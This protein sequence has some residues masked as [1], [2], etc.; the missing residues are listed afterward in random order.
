MPH[1][2]SCSFLPKI[3]AVAHSEPKT[4]PVAKESIYRY[5]FSLAAVLFA[6]GGQYA[7]DLLFDFRHQ[8]NLHF[9][10]LVT[11]A[12]PS[13][14][15]LC[16]ACDE[17]SMPVTSWWRRPIRFF[18]RHWWYGTYI[19]LFRLMTIRFTELPQ[20]K[21]LTWFLFVIM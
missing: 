6:V 19:G 5:V 12:F 14:L 2:F 20:S 7:P 11:C 15:P 21:C 3:A 17:I 4:H 8:A 13:V 16:T 10:Y 1:I 9:V 18:T